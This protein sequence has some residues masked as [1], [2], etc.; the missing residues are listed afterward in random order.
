MHI[1]HNVVN[2]MSDIIKFLP[3]KAANCIVFK[4]YDVIFTTSL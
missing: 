1:F 3:L 2:M 4:V